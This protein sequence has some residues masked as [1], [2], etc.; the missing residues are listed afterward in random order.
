MSAYN[1]VRFWVKPG[2]EGEFPDAPGYGR[3]ERPS[4]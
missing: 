1:V 2:R 4:R 3:V